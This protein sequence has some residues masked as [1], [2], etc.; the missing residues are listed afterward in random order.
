MTRLCDEHFEVL[1][2]TGGS[3]DIGRVDRRVRRI[4][5]F[6]CPSSNMVKKN[7]WANVQDLR[8]GDEVK[9]VVG[10]REDYEWLK[11]VI[12]QHGMLQRCP[13][14]I[15]PTFG[16]L[17]PATVAEW[18]LADRLDVRLQL[19]IHKYIWSAEAKGV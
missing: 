19:Q 14:L 15:S 11:Q 2:E 9:F 8:S 16:S 13:V 7:L 18:I 12:D 1:L 3:L 6:K 4:V 10:N 17:E 5:D